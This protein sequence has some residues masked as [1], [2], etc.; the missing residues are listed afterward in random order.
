MLPI[1][2]RDIDEDG[3]TR[4]LARTTKEKRLDFRRGKDNKM[5]SHVSQYNYVYKT[6]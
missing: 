3:D 5:L 6:M 2:P 4:H 1:I